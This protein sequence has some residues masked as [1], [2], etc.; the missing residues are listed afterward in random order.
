MNT[1][2]IDEQILQDMIQALS[3]LDADAQRQAVE[4]VKGIPAS[5]EGNNAL[6][7]LT[8]AEYEAF[9]AMMAES[10]RVSMDV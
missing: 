4:Y 10:D 9:M 5:T 2:P 7:V 3:R 1:S 8:K 6:F